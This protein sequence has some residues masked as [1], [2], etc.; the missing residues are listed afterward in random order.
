MWSVC[1]YKIHPNFAHNSIHLLQMPLKR[2]VL[3]V[4]SV[5]NWVFRINGYYFKMMQH[6]ISNRLQWQVLLRQINRLLTTVFTWFGWFRSFYELE[7]YV[8]VTHYSVISHWNEKNQTKNNIKLAHFFI[9]IIRWHFLLSSEVILFFQTNS[10]MMQHDRC[11]I[12]ET[13]I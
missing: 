2:E 6:F 5:W 9:S 7:K 4:D 11:L 13:M 3:Y 12:S 8:H 10:E 1:L